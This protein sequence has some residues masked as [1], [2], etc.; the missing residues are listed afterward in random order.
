MLG[1]L[2]FIVLVSVSLQSALCFA[3]AAR[4]SRDGVV[5]TSVGSQRDNAY[6]VV[7]QPDG[8]AVV[9]GA[10]YNGKD[11]DIAVLRYS[12]NGRLDRNFGTG[13]A[14][15]IDSRMGD[16]K[17]TALAL[18][19]D[20]RIVVVGS[21]FN[22]KDT[23]FMTLRLLPDGTL[24][25]SFGRKG[26]IV[27]DFGSGNDQAYSVLLEPD[28]KIIVGG[29]ASNGKDLDF[30]MVRYDGAGNRDPK[31]GVDGRAIVGL[32]D[33]D[34]LASDDY[35]YALVRQGD[36]RLILVGY[37]QTTQSSVFASCRFFANGVL[38]PTYGKSGIVITPV[39]PQ[40][41]QAFAAAVQSDGKLIVAGASSDR[42]GTHFALVRY[43]SN[44][45]LDTSFGKKGV[46]TTVVGNSLDVIYA[47]QVDHENT[48]TVAGSSF[49]SNDVDLVVARYN[50]SG[51]L[52]N[53]FGKGG[54]AASAISPQYD[55][56]YSLALENDGKILAAGVAGQGGVYQLAL[57]RL[58]NDGQRDSSFGDDVGGYQAARTPATS[59]FTAEM[60]IPGFSFAL[61]PM[62][63]RHNIQP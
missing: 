11:T 13:G 53:S 6:G 24:D 43:N 16:D 2:K 41:D 9:A 44:G 14:V 37:S 10:S 28:G 27:E 25:R 1:R 18:Q 57:E 17:A 7:V 31:F 29:S 58:T 45:K 34:D 40:Q 12:S 49:T 59:V 4:F 8:K 33:S 23:D 46:V 50:G 61:P 60:G 35:G 56:A 3:E 39:G 47:I 38:D 22:G 63:R 5:L 62:E 20:G 48:I 32:G 42:K 30:A 52:D 19:P 26:M 54:I 51:E 15:I 55:A 36:G 21:V